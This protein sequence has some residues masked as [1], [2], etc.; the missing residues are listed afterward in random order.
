MVGAGSQAA[1][2]LRACSWKCH[3]LVAWWGH[4]SD[5]LPGDRSPVHRFWQMHNYSPGDGPCP[6]AGHLLWPSGWDTS[7]L[8]GGMGPNWRD[9][10]WERIG[11]ILFSWSQ[12]PWVSPLSGPRCWFCLVSPGSSNG[13]RQIRPVEMFWAHV[14]I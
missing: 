9:G 14:I 2:I 10:I 5:L 8:G 4:R 6:L 7:P 13:A 3:L 11:R 1:Y 12:F